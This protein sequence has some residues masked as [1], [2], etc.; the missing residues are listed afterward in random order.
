MNQLESWGGTPDK[1]LPTN[2]NEFAARACAMKNKY[3]VETRTS[4]GETIYNPVLYEADLKWYLPAQNQAPDMRDNLSGNYW[5]S[6]A[7]I[8]P[9]TTAYK[10]SVGGAT[11]PEDRNS[12][13]H[14]RAVR[15]RP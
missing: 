13:L 2:P 11:S 8:D 3:H 7:I 15:N 14:V 12:G 4:S 1:T 5:T 6:T 10:Y 9:G